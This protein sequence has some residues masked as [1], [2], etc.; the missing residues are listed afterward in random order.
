VTPS[1]IVELRIE[2]D[3]FPIEVSDERGI[4]FAAVDG[5][6]NRDHRLR[7]LKATNV[8][9]DGIVRPPYP[10]FALRSTASHDDTPRTECINRYHNA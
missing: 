1:P 9:M 6:E 2:E 5:L 8:D 10:G 4:D 7:R 3:R